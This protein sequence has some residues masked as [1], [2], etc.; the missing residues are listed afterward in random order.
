[1][2]IIYLECFSYSKIF[3]DF[4]PYFGEGEVQRGPLP[5]P[6]RVALDEVVLRLPPQDPIGNV[7]P[8]A[9]A[10]DDSVPRSL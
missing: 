3:G 5:E 7:L 2:N 9:A 1:M 10:V 6:L 4:L 8:G